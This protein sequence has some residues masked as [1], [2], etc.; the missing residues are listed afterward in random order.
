[1]VIC[2]AQ[3]PIGVIMNLDNNDLAM[4]GK[5]LLPAEKAPK[6]HNKQHQSIHCDYALTALSGLINDMPLMPVPAM[7]LLVRDIVLIARYHEA[8]ARPDILGPRGPPQ[9]S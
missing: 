2:S 5:A 8:N 4:R 7:I 9:I 6:K 1:M 3:G